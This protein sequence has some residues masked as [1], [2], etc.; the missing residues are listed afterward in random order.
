[1]R[2]FPILEPITLTIEP[3]RIPYFALSVGRS[4]D[5]ADP[6]WTLNGCPTEGLCVKLTDRIYAD[7]AGVKHDVRS[8][9]ALVQI[10]D[11]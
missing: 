3:L 11:D 2:E 6:D 4:F 5:W 1:M 10:G 8:T 7:Q 9:E